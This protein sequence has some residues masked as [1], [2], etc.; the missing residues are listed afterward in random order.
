MKNTFFTRQLI[1]K[2]FALWL[3]LLFISPQLMAQPSRKIEQQPTGAAY[4][5]AIGFHQRGLYKEALEQYRKAMED[6]ANKVNGVSNIILKNI[7]HCEY[8]AKRKSRP[9]Q[10]T[11]T[12]LGTDVNKP[13]VS[14][15][16]AFAGGKEHLFV[17]STRPED[18]KDE[19]LDHVYMAKF[20][21]AP[22]Q[23]WNVSLVGK[24]SRKNY[25]EGVTG[26][27]P[28]GKE[29]FIFRGSGNL[30]VFNF[31]AQKEVN[32]EDIPFTPLSKIY[33]LKLNDD[34]HISSLAINMERNAIYLCMNDQGK[35]GG[36]GGYD[37]WQ[38][39][40]D[41][42]SK[43]WDKLVNLGAAV[44]TEGDEISVSLQPD[45]KAIFFSS[46]GHTGFGKLDI[47]RSEYA[48]ATSSWGEPVHLGYPINTPNDDIYYTL[49]PGNPKC[50][51]YSSE[52][53]DGS[54]MY[55]IHLVTYYGRIMSE[56]E[57]EKLRTAYL[58]SVEDAQKALKPSDK[59][60]PSE[61]KLLS[62]K[63][64][65]SFPTD[66]VVVGMKIYLQNIQFANAKATLLPKSHK[67][68]D[69]LYRLMLYFP[70]IKIEISGHSDNVGSKKKNLKLSQD[71]A[72]SVVEYLVER[73]VEADRMSAIGYGDTQPLSS[74]KTD[75]GK[76]LN[77]RVEVKIVEL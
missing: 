12:K 29:F 23:R 66:S 54:G 40:Y 37:I 44:N 26:M 77:R 5:K 33:N 64:Y 63:G 19:V 9:E 15:I 59:L 20:E 47:Y 10:V 31:D 55:D 18:G 61:T 73:G 52:R 45:G 16:N 42:S 57:R 1:L 24:K 4:K 38:T 25:H 32:A 2:Q 46:N 62:K 69:Q 67:Q 43:S 58:K 36:R 51:Y 22:K 74:N 28:D 21:S 68:L 14:N 17:T 60:K 39:T 70:S 30:F 41:A 27:S 65:N 6:Q 56:E 7:E 71:R 13:K 11:V 53:A 3:L 35:M 76:A 34:Y 49:V 48:D 75:D 8:G 72:A 50:A